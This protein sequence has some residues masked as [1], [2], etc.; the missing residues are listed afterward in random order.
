[1]KI[2]SSY[3]NPAFNPRTL[4]FVIKNIANVIKNIRKQ[5]HFD[6]IAFSGMSGAAIAF[7]ISSMMNINLLLIR[8]PEENSYRVLHQ[9]EILDGPGKDISSCVILDDLIKTGKTIKR[10][11]SVLQEQKIFCHG[12]VLWNSNASGKNVSEVLGDEF[13]SL[14]EEFSKLPCWIV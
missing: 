6:A 3:L 4:T 5:K 13:C 7:P 14:N 8:K 2:N 1:M 12:V 10:M 11:L 9:G